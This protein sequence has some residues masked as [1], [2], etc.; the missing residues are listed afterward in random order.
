MDTLS[1]NV[2]YATGL[3]REVVKIAIGHV[4]LFLR[5]E[6]P[7]AHV[8][9]FIDKMG[10]PSEALHAAAAVDGGGTKGAIEG[11]GGSMGPRRAD[12][13]ILA[14]ELKKLGLTETQIIDLLK[15]IVARARELID[16]EDVAKIEHLLA[17]LTER[18]G[19]M[20]GPAHP[21]P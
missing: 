10:Q 17:S 3:R 21:G 1:R 14:G 12:V 2:I 7:E 19:H 4:L 9:E 18:S 8:S 15:Q 13:H 16:A 5:A 20:A 6:A 11:L